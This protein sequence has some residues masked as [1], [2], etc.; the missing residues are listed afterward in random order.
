M[1]D[2]LVAGEF[3]HM[4]RRLAKKNAPEWLINILVHAA[5]RTRGNRGMGGKHRRDRPVCDCVGYFRATGFPPRYDGECPRCKSVERYRLLKL[6]IDREAI[7]GP[8]DRVLA[9][10]GRLI[11]TVP[12]VE[13]WAETYEDDAISIPCERDLY[14]GQ[15]D[16]LRFYGADLRDRFRDAGFATQEYTAVEPDVSRHGLIRGEKIFI[17]IKG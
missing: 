11:V 7:I 1:A 4:F 17:G 6:A 13:G 15:N 2:G 5:F 16:H 12:V 14:F 10:G 3:G 8:D 9:P